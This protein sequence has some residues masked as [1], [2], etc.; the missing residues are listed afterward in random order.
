MHLHA[1]LVQS[2]RLERAKDA[3][4]HEIES[5]RHSGGSSPIAPGCYPQGPSV[6]YYTDAGVA[7][8]CSRHEW[9]RHLNSAARL[10]AEPLEG[11]PSWF[12][13][14]MY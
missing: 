5:A 7:V 3:F 2:G 6:L 9:L 1:R 4:G 8:E 10:G 12:R 14:W 13:L 11:V